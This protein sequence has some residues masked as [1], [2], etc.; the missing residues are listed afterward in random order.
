MVRELV[1]AAGTNNAIKF[2]LTRTRAALSVVSGSQATTWAWRSGQITVVE[3]DTQFVG[4]AI[5]DP[6]DYNLNDVAGMLQTA[7]RLSRS[8]Q[9]QELQIVE[10]A[11]RAVYM[12]VTTNPESQTIFF[13]KDGRLVTPLDL[14]TL[15]GVTEALRDTVAGKTSVLG[16]GI[17]PN[18]GGLWVDA[19]AA[20]QTVIRTL[21]MP[22]F[23]ARS[24]ARRDPGSAHPFDP[25]LVSPE[26][27]ISTRDR[28]LSK[29]KSSLTPSWSVTI[30]ARTRDQGPGPRMYWSLA[31]E[32][33][34]TTLAGVEVDKG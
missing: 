22:R 3:S 26:V 31:G 6:R 4:Q 19:T 1:E 12:T 17:L 24:S 2:E 7:G 21:R 34:T 18:Q 27:V 28:L 33:V 13:H 20:G 11:D 30:E 29:L 8:S 14:S 16:I 23:P 9:Q 25:A 15:E 32:S 5:F 10:Y